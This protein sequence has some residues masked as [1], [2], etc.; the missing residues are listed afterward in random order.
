MVVLHQGWEYHFDF[1][2]LSDLTTSTP[3]G[4]EAQVAFDTFVRTFAFLPIT[5]TPVPPAPLVTPVL[6]AAASPSIA[7]TT[8]LKG[9]HVARQ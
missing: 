3:D 1:Y 2:P 8:A 7:H 4:V 5:E 6:P 9:R